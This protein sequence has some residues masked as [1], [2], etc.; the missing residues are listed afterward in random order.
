MY[1]VR[2]DFSKYVPPDTPRVDVVV[3]FLFVNIFFLLDSGAVWLEKKMY[4][5]K[6]LCFATLCFV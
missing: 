1:F 5:G 2:I 4:S 6:I 3:V